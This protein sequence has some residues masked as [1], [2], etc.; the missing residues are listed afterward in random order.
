MTVAQASILLGFN[1][2]DLPVLITKRL[3]RPLGK[4]APNAIKYFARRDIEQLA[5]DSGWLSRATQTMYDHWHKRNKANP[6][7]GNR[8]GLD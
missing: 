2:I 8:T 6:K 3:L 5:D 7:R 1:S 4:P